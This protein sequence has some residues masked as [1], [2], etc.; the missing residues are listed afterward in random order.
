MCV[1]YSFLANHQ[2]VLDLP[3]AFDAAGKFSGSGLGLRRV[4]KAA[5]LHDVL[6][7][8]D[9][10]LHHLQRGIVEHRGF[11]FGRDCRVVDVFASGLRPD[12]AEQAA[13][14]VVSASAT[15]TVLS[16]LALPMA[17]ASVPL[18]ISVRHQS[19]P[20]RS[21]HPKS[22][23]NID[24]KMFPLACREILPCLN[25]IQ[26]FAQKNNP[27]CSFDVGRKIMI[28]KRE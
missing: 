21:S 27:Y 9:A 15:R 1:S 25:S 5:Q 18:L 6:H 26:Q 20:E 28:T 19:R 2:V 24:T 3:H 14:E 16:P 4:N 13:R 17:G 23:V 11:D 7:G 8:L 12:I 10:D 22:L